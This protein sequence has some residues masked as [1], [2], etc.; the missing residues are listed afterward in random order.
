M[1]TKALKNLQQREKNIERARTLSNR[2]VSYL[3]NVEWWD[4]LHPGFTY[5]YLWQRMRDYGIDVECSVVW[6]TS[7]ETPHDPDN[8][9]YPEYPLLAIQVKPVQGQYF[10]T[11]RPT[12]VWSPWHVSICFKSDPHTIHDIAYLVNKFDDKVVRL[13]L[14]PT[15]TYRGS[16]IDL[17]T[18]RDPIASDPIVQKL[19]SNGYYGG[20]P[21]HISL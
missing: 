10:P 5:E 8:S 6:L 2:G 16:S 7:L 11:R 1:F 19:H 12:N 21:I 13:V 20:K 3:K 14:E 9:G 15:E 4:R 18:N 17:D